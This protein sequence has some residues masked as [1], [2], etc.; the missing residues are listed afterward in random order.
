MLKTVKNVTLNGESMIGEK[1]AMGFSA[2]INGD[3]PA[4]I[5]LSNWQNDAELY[6]ENKAECR[7]DYADFVAKAYEIQDEMLGEKEE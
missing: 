1:S 7:K 6:K 5:A 3:N 2:V 4:N